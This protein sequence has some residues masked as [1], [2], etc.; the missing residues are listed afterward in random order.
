MSIINK[1]NMLLFKN[2]L[3]Q[4]LK[5]L[6]KMALEHGIRAFLRQRSQVRISVA[7]I[8]IYCTRYWKSCSVHASSPK[9]IRVRGVLKYKTLPGPSTISLSFWLRWFLKP[10]AYKG[11]NTMFKN[12]LNQKFKLLVGMILEHGIRAL[13]R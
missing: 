13:L 9:G 4:K 2:Q 8:L 12:Q 6:V 1:M 5:L 3:N 11:S 7:S 10:I